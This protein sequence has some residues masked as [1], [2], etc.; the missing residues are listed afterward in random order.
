MSQQVGGAHAIHL[1]KGTEKALNQ[2]KHAAVLT[3]DEEPVTKPAPS[4]LSTFL[5][6]QQD[7]EHIREVMKKLE[8]GKRLHGDLQSAKSA[9]IALRDRLDYLIDAEGEP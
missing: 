6:A 9:A 7:I 8:P 5:A 2:Y 3:S 4:A 1:S